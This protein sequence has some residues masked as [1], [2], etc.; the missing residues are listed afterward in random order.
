MQALTAFRKNARWITIAFLVAVAIVANRPSAGP[1]RAASAAELE[2]ALDGVRQRLP[3]RTGDVE[4]QSAG[5]DG[6]V[7]VFRAVDH[8]VAPGDPIPDSAEATIR[9]NLLTALHANPSYC[10]LM[11]EL[12]FVSRYIYS[13]PDGRLIAIVQLGPKD[14]CVPDQE[15]AQ[16]RPATKAPSQ[17]P[18][19][20]KRVA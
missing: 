4:V 13:A 2:H 8:S 9:S 12:D 20:T 19:P 15:P 3:Q 11:S 17:A 6:R 16:R 5:L 7:I 18:A 14:V 1:P 10:Q